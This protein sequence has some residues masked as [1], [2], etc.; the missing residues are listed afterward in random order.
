MKTLRRQGALLF[1][2]FVLVAPWSVEAQAQESAQAPAQAGPLA[3]LDAY[4]EQAMAAWEVPGLALAVV[5]G[6]SLLR[7]RGYGV[8]RLGGAEGVDGSTLF[9]IASTSKAFT[10]AALALLVDEGKLGWDDPVRRHLPAFQVADPQVSGALTVRD[11]VTHRSGLARLDNLWIGGALD[12]GGIM[13]RLRHLPQA[14][15]FRDRYGYNNL[16][17]IAAGELA[18][19]VAGTSWDA[20]LE[21]RIFGPLGMTRTTTRDAVVEAQEN[22]AH[23]HARVDGAVMAVPRRAYD[24]IGGAGAVWSSAEELAHWMRMH[25]AGGV[26]EGARILS[27]DRIRELWTPVIPMAIDSTTRRLH[28]TNAFAAYALGWRVQDL[29]GSRLVHHSGSIN[30]TRTHLLLVPDDGI[31]IVAMANL[32]SSNLQ[33]ALAHWILDALQ[34]REPEDWSALY[35]ELQHRSEAQSERSAAELE[36]ARL[37]GVGPSLPLDRYAG[38]YVDDL[39]GELRIEAVPGAA[40]EPAALLRLHYSDVYVADLTPWHQDIFRVTWAHPAAGR[41]FVRFALDPRGRITAAS[42][43]GWAEFRRVGG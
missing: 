26:F 41:T 42:L 16:A 15:A 11:L 13:E 30:Y 8:T 24:Q 22:V 38:R 3:G 36:A 2:T 17:Y 25:L 14:D 12:R 5:Q 10:T 34:G 28:P 18:G 40:G 33:L 20:L 19:S 35:L 31:G 23:S 39:F 43:D 7:L 27:E 1:A 29:N 37:E 9:A 32:S 4:V 6:D 21:T